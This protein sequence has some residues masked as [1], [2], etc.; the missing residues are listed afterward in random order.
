MLYIFTSHCMWLHV[1][2]SSVTSPWS[3]FLFSTTQRFTVSIDLMHKFWSCF[4]IEVCRLKL[5]KWIATV[6]KMSKFKD[7][8][9]L[10]QFILMFFILIS[11]SWFN[12]IVSRNEVKVACEIHRI[13]SNERHCECI[14]VT[15]RDSLAHQIASQF[16]ILH[17]HT[18][19]LYVYTSRCIIMLNIDVGVVW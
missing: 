1:G 10:L 18:I 5:I 11:A 14:C 13:L 12:K 16:T 8:D 15:E 9:L 19:N 17:G 6:A 2:V 7:L 3:G 4:L